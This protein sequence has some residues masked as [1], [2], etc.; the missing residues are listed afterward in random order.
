MIP[1][2]PME[3]VLVK[4]PTRFA[5]L[6]PGLPNPKVLMA[7]GDD[8]SDLLGYYSIREA[9]LE[10]VLPDE[11]EHYRA[12]YFDVFAPRPTR[13]GPPYLALDLWQRA[14]GR[15]R[16]ELYSLII[17]TR[18]L[19][20]VSKEILGQFEEKILDQMDRAIVA[21]RRRERDELRY[22]ANIF[23]TFISMFVQRLEFENLRQANRAKL[24]RNFLV[25]YLGVAAGLLGIF[26]V[27]GAL[28]LFPMN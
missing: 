4:S 21:L 23:S 12:S 3:A 10:G 7:S 18:D 26:A 6:A 16:D 17:D 5:L 9:G 27:S 11:G 1:D 14:E 8:V 2:E 20:L 13:R 28:G 25:L 15:E 22:V 24:L 19:P